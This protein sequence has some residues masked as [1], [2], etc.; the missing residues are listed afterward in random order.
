MCFFSGGKS[1][2]FRVIPISDKLLFLKENSFNN[3]N[4]LIYKRCLTTGKS[5][6]KTINEANVHKN[7]YQTP[8][9]QQQIPTSDDHKN[10]QSSEPTTNSTTIT[11]DDNIW[12]RQPSRDIHV[13]PLNVNTSTGLISTSTKDGKNSH[14][15]KVHTTQGELNITDRFKTFISQSD[16]TSAQLAKAAAVSAFEQV[17]PNTPLTSSTRT[18]EASF[19]PKISST[20]TYSKSSSIAADLHSSIS[21]PSQNTKIK[22]ET[23]NQSKVSGGQDTFGQ[24]I[25]HPRE[26]LFYIKGKN[27]TSD[28]NEILIQ[29]EIAIRN[30]ILRESLNFVHEKGWTIEAI[31]AGIKKCNQPD[32]TE[33][34]F[35][36]GYDLVEYFMRT[37]NAKMAV[38]M[39]E[40]TNKDHIEGTRLLIEGL[41]YRLKLV[42]PYADTW[43]QALA[44]KGLPPNAKRAWKSLLDLANQAWL[45][46]GDTSTD[47]KW[48]TKRISIATI[49][50]S[51]EIYMLQDKSPNKIETMNFIE[52]HLGD[53]ETLD[54]IRTSVSQ[55]LSD[56]AQVASGL[57]TVVRSM[58]NRHK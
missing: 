19:A 23:I 30:Q 46:I 51:A 9:V 54:T 41:K 27:N 39:N 47:M 48:Y 24:T 7:I 13:S 40:L 14:E 53:F 15:T 44:Q 17:A 37:S 38:Y 3:V 2:L 42:I 6:P 35:Y 58:T 31:R 57:L 25:N 4:N 34:L 10:K 18:T 26:D 21:L 56:T 29:Q 16:I 36:N 43:E 12:S 28:S 11:N 8:I 20:N 33:G 49:Y 50:R 52:R 45:S 32:T 1:R 55:S 5:S 22:Y